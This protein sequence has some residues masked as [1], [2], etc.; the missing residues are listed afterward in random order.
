M[1][2]K[3]LIPGLLLFLFFTLSN[4]LTGQFY[5][6][7]GYQTPDANEK[8]IVYWLSAIPSSDHQYSFFGE[9]VN[10]QG[11]LAHSL[12]IEYGISNHFTMAFYL[13]FEQPPGKDLKLI[14]TKTVM[15][16]YRFFEKKARPV[17]MAIYLEYILPRKGY[18]NS[19]ELELKFILEKD[20]GFHTV[21][22]NPTFEKKISGEDVEEGVEFAFNAGYYYKKNLRIQP[23]LEIYSKMGELYDMKG[24][25]DQKNYIFPSVDL[26]L[27]KNYALH[28]HAGIGIGLTD[29]ADNIILK[30]ILSFELF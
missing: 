25:Q 2:R 28:W 5:K 16:H 24:F 18:K 21:V 6:I 9:E 13:D 10:R 19:E 14:K 7:Y 15:L 20:M 3:T 30:S 27:G 12:E 22:L 8:E 11:L 1:K 17:D 23:G 4:Q 26:F 29:P